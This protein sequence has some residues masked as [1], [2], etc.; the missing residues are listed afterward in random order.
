LRTVRPFVSD[1]DA[2]REARDA[3]LEIQ[4]A[5]R[6]TEHVL[7]SAWIAQPDDNIGGWC[8]TL[9]IPATPAQGNPAIADFCDLKV[10][11]HIVNL[12][13][14]HIAREIGSRDPA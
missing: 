11:Q 8:V 10:A 5:R 13:N 6:Q 9:A 3:G 14:A 1:R 7:R 4:K 2:F 12:H